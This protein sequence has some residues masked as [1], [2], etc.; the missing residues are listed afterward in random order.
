VQAALTVSTVGGLIAGGAEVPGA[1]QPEAGECGV[2]L[3]HQGT[4]WAWLMGPF[5]TASVKVHGG[6]AAAQEQASTWMAGFCARLHVVGL[7]AG[8]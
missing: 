4:V 6:S 8:L 5:I 2:E 1:E 7:G 3:L